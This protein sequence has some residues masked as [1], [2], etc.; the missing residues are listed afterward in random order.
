MWR[1]GLRRDRRV[2]VLRPERIVIADA[3]CAGRRCQAQRERAREECPLHLFPQT[4]AVRS[5]EH[6]SELQSLMRNSYDVFC[7]KKKTKTIKTNIDEHK[8]T[9]IQ[10][11]HQT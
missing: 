1:C 3:R 4:D 11:Q 2:V 8:I 9:T 7:L 5:E 6:T 10:T